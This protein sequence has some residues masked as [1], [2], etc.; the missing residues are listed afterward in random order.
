MAFASK[1]LLVHVGNMP[2]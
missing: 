2:Q 1:A